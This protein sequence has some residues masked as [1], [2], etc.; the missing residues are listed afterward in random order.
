MSEEKY[1]LDILAF[2]RIMKV[3]TLNPQGVEMANLCQLY[4]Q[5]NLSK[6]FD[7]YPKALS[8]LHTLGYLHDYKTGKH[9]GMLMPTN[10]SLT[11]MKHL[12]TTCRQKKKVVKTRSYTGPQIGLIKVPKEVKQ[13]GRCDVVISSI[14]NPTEF[15]FNIKGK[16]YSQ[17]LEKLTTKMTK[18]Y[19]SDKKYL[20]QSPILK[21]IRHPATVAAPY[22]SGFYRAMVKEKVCR[23]SNTVQVLF[24]DYGNV[25]R[26]HLDQIYLLAPEFCHLPW[27]GVCGNEVNL[28]STK[29][30]VL[31]IESVVTIL[32]TENIIGV[33]E[34]EF[35]DDGWPPHPVKMKLVDNN[36]QTILSLVRDTLLPDQEDIENA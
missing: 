16:H 1:R 21:N 31:D 25:E 28:S 2:T 9:Q 23:T 11:I 33:F 8:A 4:Q 12:F 7:D 30:D 24:P 20:Y 36:H 22:Q 17:E 15:F 19:T 13:N 5:V 35:D 18:L 26:V 32:E 14:E 27:Q 29:V 3:F 6:I 10:K 34:E